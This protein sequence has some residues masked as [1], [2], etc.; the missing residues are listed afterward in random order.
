MEDNELA[1]Q[2]QLIIEDIIYR[3]E[4]VE[5]TV[6]DLLFEDLSSKEKMD[7]IYWFKDNVR[8]LYSV[9]NKIKEVRM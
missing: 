4:S 3:I 2:S 6:A 5:D 9:L 1:V 8:E 7:K